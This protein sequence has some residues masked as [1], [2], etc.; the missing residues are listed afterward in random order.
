MDFRFHLS[1]IVG[2]ENVLSSP[3]NFTNFGKN[4]TMMNNFYPW[5]TIY[6]AYLLSKMCNSLLI[7]YYVYCVFLT[8]LT[9]LSSYYM[10][11][12][13]KKNQFTAVIFSIIYTFSGYRTMDVFFRGALGET[14]AL[15][16]YPL[17][18]LG[19]YYILL[20]NYKK[21]Y[22][23]TI[24]MTLTVYT[25]ALS[26]ALAV[27]YIAIVIMIA[28]PF[29]DKTMQRLVV[30]FMAT[31][32]TILLSLAYFI[33]FVEQKLFV[34]VR[35]PQPQLLFEKAVAPGELFISSLN[36]DIQSYNLGII[37]LLLLI[38]TFIKI[39]LLNNFEKVIV[40]LGVFSIIVATK[41]F[42][43]FLLQ[44]TV[45]AVIQFP[46]RFLTGATIFIAF[47]GAVL[48]NQIYKNRYTKSL[49]LAVFLLFI[50][51]S[52]V[53][54]VSTTAQYK[55]NLKYTQAETEDVARV[56]RH[57]DYAPK[58][59]LDHN[60]FFQYSQ[61]SIDGK[62]YNDIEQKR[63]S[64]SYQITFNNQVREGVEAI[65]PIYRYKGQIVTMNDKIVPV[66]EAT[67]GGTLLS[68]PAGKVDVKITYKYTFL[69]RA[70]QIF[71]LLIMLFFGLYLYRKKQ[72]TLR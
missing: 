41:L 62:I 28:L 67:N 46:W 71:S 51:V 16:F 58:V 37:I 50:T 18:F 61:V 20:G 69:A 52:H 42:P 70:S 53:S 25:H 68:L 23:L 59:A 13:I 35:I 12:C 24:G 57:W 4:G 14:V 65:V 49:F 33:P 31:V 27:G 44:S 54:A 64:S 43:W 21:W 9:F 2:L 32:M 8:F 1:R 5:L 26:V 29:I 36:N 3:V 7:G 47:S 34:N 10:M 22:W 66:K 55:N 11:I 72:R 60:D 38:L 45:L 6:P 39:D 17:I 40:G 48:L 63:T 30:L 19:M 56:Y 15:A